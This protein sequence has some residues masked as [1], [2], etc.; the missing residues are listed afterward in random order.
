MAVESSYCSNNTSLSD[1]WIQHG[2]SHCFLDTLISSLLFGFILIFGGTQILIYRKRS[3]PL[4]VQFQ[5]KPHWYYVQVTLTV[6]IAL[7]YLLR[8]LLEINVIH[9]PVFIYNIVTTVFFI[10]AWL[11]SLTVLRV[12]RK[13][14]LLNSRRV[15]HGAVLLI[16][17]A[18]ALL[19]DIPAFASWSSPLWWWKLSS[20]KDNIEFSMW[21]TRFTC[22]L[23]VFILGLRA[24]G[25]P[26]KSYML[27]VNEDRDP[28][29]GKPLLDDAS[30]TG[31]SGEY[32]SISE[33]EGSA[34]KGFYRKSKLMWPHV[35]PSGHPILQ[36][37]VVL[38][39]IILLANRG[40]NVLVPLYYKYIVDALTP[41]SSLS[42]FFSG[43]SSDNTTT[44]PSPQTGLVFPWKDIMIYVLLKFLQGGLGV[45][46]IGFLNNI[47]TFMWIKVQQYTSRTIQ[48][49][50]FSHLHS[51]SLRWHLG[52][53]TGEVLRLMDRGTQSI[54]N[55]L[56]YVLFNIVP[57]IVDIIIAI[58][59]FTTA[60]NI[61]F[62]LIV[63]IAMA[64]YLGATIFI[65]EWRTKFR[66]KMN[67]LDNATKQKAVDS[68]LNFETV[69]YYGAEEHEVDRL[70]DA[71]AAYQ[72]TEWVSLASLN[73]LNTAQN[74]I[75]TVGLLAGSLLCAR[76]V[77][78]G[79][80]TVGDYVLFSTYIIQ[81]Y[82]PLNFFGTYYRM[83]QQSYVDMEN[84]MDLLDAKQEV[85]DIPN[86]PDLRVSQGLVEF[87]NVSFYYNQQKP[88]LQNVSFR[89][90]PGKT[91]ALVGHSGAGKSTI[92]RLLFRFYDIHGGTIKIDG[93]DISQVTQSSLR[94][95]IGVVPQDTVLF[96]NDI[97]FNI[98][99]G[100]IEASDEEIE[101]ASRAADIHDRIETFPDGYET[102]VGERGLKLSGGEKQRVAIARTIL[103]A[104][105]VVLLDEATS[106]LDTKTER[107]I[108]QSL[109]KVCTNRTTIIVAHRLSTI[110][111]ADEILVLKEGYVIERGRHE[112]LLAFGQE[113][114]EMWQQQLQKAEDENNVQNL[115]REGT[116]E[117]PKKTD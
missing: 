66:R 11:F 59:Y 102:V 10:L 62:G 113:Y 21:V 37:L 117:S 55:L 44:T 58:I 8:I 93:K 75:I 33:Q 111:H 50:L 43:Y 97:R 103:K 5:P 9:D 96:N 110:I 12:E 48:I 54:N 24:P 2:I 42:E 74:I 115:I 88:I 64:L 34:W 87:D 25:L 53:K 78:D 3:V 101:T 1:V 98:R 23:L 91:L 81:L 72:S 15:G 41:Q 73:I 77:V 112:E 20:Q 46:S 30:P 51:L 108:Q 40:I 109:D 83:I 45:G 13:R 71:I 17:W 18:L 104:P 49:R 116:A 19:G 39:F 36:L 60:F 38:C 114:A 82:G 105:Q 56:N 86:A 100:R 65:T 31:T 22:T 89:V 61:Y 106:A 84:M 32:Q 6:V 14:T 35:W 107:N 99:F 92:V 26:K 76:D 63:F 47:R 80:L 4:D 90:E 28:E 95:A 69:K 16:F 79:K 29:Q 7:Q 70:N 52:R 67:I 94:Q 85:K 57:T 27:L 68:L